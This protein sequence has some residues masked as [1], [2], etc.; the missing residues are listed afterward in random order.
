VLSAKQRERWE[1]LERDGSL[2]LVHDIPEGAV[3]MVRSGS[4]GPT[5]FEIVEPEP[6]HRLAW[7]TGL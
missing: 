1:A 7:D 3:L 6:T 5:W 2:V 4:N